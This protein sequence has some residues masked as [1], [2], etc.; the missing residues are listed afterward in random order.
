[1]KETPVQG[2][3]LTPLEELHMDNFKLSNL[4]QKYGFVLAIFKPS[5]IGK[6]MQNL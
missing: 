6:K 5:E 4:K 1:M 3:V 2:T